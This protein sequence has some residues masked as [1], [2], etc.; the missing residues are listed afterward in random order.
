MFEQTALPHLNA[1]YNLARW[2]TRNEDDAKDIVQ[3]SY[4]RAF[5]LFESYHGGD[6]KA[7]ILAVVRNTY[8]TWRSRTYRSRETTLSLEVEQSAE[9]NTVSPLDR[10]VDDVRLGALRNCIEHLPD[11]YREVLVMRELEEMS[12]QQIADTMNLPTGTVMS[13]LS[14][15]RKR[16]AQCVN[17][18]TAG[19]SR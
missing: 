13:R 7:W 8:L 15:A 18:R 5:R 11:E 1:A 17:G 16:L 12:Y 2:L 6:G 3:E 4:L 14:R 9:S 19:A 10:L